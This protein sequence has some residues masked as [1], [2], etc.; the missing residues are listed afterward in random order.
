MRAALK[1]ALYRK[2]YIATYRISLWSG[3]RYREINYGGY[4][5]LH[6]TRQDWNG[7]TGGRVRKV[8]VR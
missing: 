8:E 3:K 1:I 4:E 6:R 5:K 7:P 2:L